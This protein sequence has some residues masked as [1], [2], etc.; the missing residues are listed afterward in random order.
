[1]TS[2]LSA[3]DLLC[4]QLLSYSPWQ[5]FNELNYGNKFLLDYDLFLFI[6]FGQE[7]TLDKSNRLFVR[8]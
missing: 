2:F 5:I 3:E 6:M 4:L 7:I 8:P 1:M